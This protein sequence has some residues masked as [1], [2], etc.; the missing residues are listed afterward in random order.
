MARLVLPFLLLSVLTVATL[1]AVAYQ[2]ARASLQGQ[3]FDRLAGAAE[4]KTDALDRWVDDQRRNV[5]FVAG[6][7]GG[8]NY[9]GGPGKSLDTLRRQL[10]VLVNA[11]TSPRSEGA[12][13]GIVQVLNFVV[14]NTA[15][16]QEL[17]IV[18]QDGTIIASTVGEHEGMDESNQPFF[19]RG[20]SNTFLQP[21]SKSALSKSSVITV[22]TPLFDQHG[23]ML[24]VVAAILN[25][26]RLDRI[27]LQQTGL[28][29]TGQTYLVGTD[30]RFVHQQL[31]SQYPDPVH[32]R[33]IDVA[34]QQQDGQALYDNYAGEP[35]IG[36]YRWLPETNSALLAEMSQH[37]AF[38]P[39]R[40]LAFTIAL[41][42]AAIT[43][44]IGVGVYV[45]SRRIAK[46]IL[47]ITETA[48][49]VTAGDLDRT[50][51]VTTNDEV[52]ELA[53]SF[54]TMTARLRGTLEGLEQRVAERTEELHVQNTELE[55]LHETTLGVMDRLDVE[56]LL[57][58]LLERAGQLAGTPHGYIYLENED[59][60]AIE[61]RVSVGLLQEDLGRAVGHGEGLAGRV[62]DSGEPLV[63]EDYDAWE[64]RS[65]TFP[66][67]KIHALAGVPLQSGRRVVGV[68]GIARDTSSARSFDEA[69]VELLQR[70][71][72]LA[73]IAL[74]NA[75]L[76]SSAQEARAEADAANAA[77][78]VFL[79]TMSHEIR[80]PMNAII[81]M[82]GLMLDTRLDDEQ[83]E[84]ASSIANSGEAL[85]AIINDILDFSK[86][87]AG[88]MELE[89]APFE[90]REVIE[91]VV[92]L[93]GPPAARK[94]LEVVAEIDPSAPAM[95]IG[96][97]SRLRQIL[98]NLLN[99]AV[100]FTDSGEVV[101][102]AWTDEPE[103]PDTHRFHITVHDTGL[104]IPP[105]RVGRLFQS[106]S[107]A[108]I[109]TSR[110]YG[111]T[112]LGLAISKRLSELM[113]G[114]MWVESAGMP[115]EGSTFHL[116]F[117][118]GMTDQQPRAADT[119]LLHGKRLLV[120][121][122]NATNRRIL[123]AQA[124]HWGMQTRVAASGEDALA[125]LEDSVADVVVS[126]VL[127]PE[128]DGLDLGRR[129]EERWP[130]IPF[131]LATSIPRREVLDDERLAATGT[132]GVIAKP[133]KA[134]T[135]LD[136]LVTALGGRAER[137]RRA[138]SG[139]GLDPDLGR[140]HPLR[141]LLAEDNVVNQKLAI[142]LLEKM[143]YRADVVG[144]GLEI[145]EALERQPYDLLLSDLQ[146]P[147]MDG[148]EA[149]R[150][151]LR[152][153]P[154]GDRPWIVAMTAE[155]M[156]GDR[157]RCL[158]AGMDDYVTKPIRP[159]ELVA[160]LRRTPSPAGGN[161][162]DVSEE[163][164]I[165]EEPAED[166]RASVDAP[167]LRRFV[168]TMGDDDPAFVQE[169]I[170]QFLTDA[171]GLIADLR[172]GLGAGDAEG[173]RRA[174]H[175]LKSNANTFGARVLGERCAALEA[176]AKAGDLGDAEA[177]I[178][179]IEA[180]FMQVQVDLP[181][182]WREIAPA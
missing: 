27:V 147:E 3:V 118:A 110:K 104:G 74:D 16:A 88:R 162:G 133:V 80:T 53:E 89:N 62:W 152:R 149:T 9:Y 180:G 103:R 19:Q 130:E 136:A 76:Y 140:T 170:E 119:H 48:A 90:V 39:A 101:L 109:S 141:I 125:L 150:E 160:A 65:P 121:D 169:M 52:G 122:D 116:V 32:S 93:I 127:M 11:P 117:T 29:A 71:A 30:G 142:R 105:D 102:S 50:A 154:D 67:G 146:M 49:A 155:A 148:L 18:G 83:E 72:R 137:P 163:V 61:N 43:L 115:G 159:G 15:D 6:L 177:S 42:G 129:I 75:R 161:A 131:V 124:A 24:G 145:L 69:E 113:D 36:V 85:L 139:N 111:G 46:P 182:T 164:A 94:G 23:Q 73:S 143:G 17:M 45:I 96:D 172:V 173:V 21:V 112:G 81:G 107:Q 132:V 34:L 38:A 92:D 57:G 60:S 58:T 114:T 70:F 4:L 178:D 78:S 51:P 59:G 2:R 99:N 126:D 175:T 95:A 82:S 54:N 1:G 77:K 176:T 174:A 123:S 66:R 167:T 64:G 84:Y 28:G 20:I 33:G 63:V 47:A 144:N 22:A 151:I 106:F 91:S 156:A 26:E 31:L 86:I 120:V 8:S 181:A 55:A 35:V 100:K 97:G 158:E 79:A 68:L 25:L 168:E 44:L 165:D 134:S 98:L 108:D 41:I 40:Q 13:D 37:E 153:W 135:L 179:A 128:M 12:H 157:E 138:E 14:S 166:G 10:R 87:E 56:E 5:V 7:L 171:P